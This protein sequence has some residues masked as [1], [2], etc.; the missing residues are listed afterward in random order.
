MPA[1]EL[2]LGYVDLA[3]HDGLPVKRLPRVPT[4]PPQDLS[5]RL[6]RAILKLHASPFG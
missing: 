2:E 4:L 3:L 5:K 6:G 1:D